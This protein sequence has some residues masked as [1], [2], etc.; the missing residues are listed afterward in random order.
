MSASLLIQTC[1][2]PVSSVQKVHTCIGTKSQG[3]GTSGRKQWP[4]VC[5]PGSPEVHSR[6]FPVC[7]PDVCFTMSSSCLRFV[8]IWMYTMAR[9]GRVWF[10]FLPW[11][12]RMERTSPGC[13]GKHPYLHHFMS[14]AIFLRQC[15]PQRYWFCMSSDLQEFCVCIIWC[16]ITGTRCCS[17]LSMWVPGVQTQMKS[18]CAKTT[19]PFPQAYPNIFLT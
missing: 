1:R 5:M 9:T 2:T 19:E 11:V 18:L 10:L 12:S 16:W 4:S 7:S 6:C 15:F 8:Y 14:P 17:S 13:D 3:K